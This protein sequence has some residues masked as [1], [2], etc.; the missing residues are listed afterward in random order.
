MS[1]H[2]GYDFRKWAANTA[3]KR[4]R[5][6]HTRWTLAVLF[7]AML[8]WLAIATFTSTP[9]DRGVPG[10]IFIWA[11]IAMTSSP[12]ARDTWLTTRGLEQFDEFERAALARATSRAYLLFVL[13]VPA[14]LGLV[15]AQL[16]FGAAIAITPR[17]L[18]IWAM[19][20]LAIGLTL[21]VLI[22]EWTVP[23]LPPAES[24]DL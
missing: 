3:A 4:P 8:T 20:V 9:E 22:A 11:P 17:L 15:A 5:R 19:A 10:V 18:V 16:H 2:D 24:E 23:I 6:A 21:P 12:F 13:G 1:T 14:A 7:A